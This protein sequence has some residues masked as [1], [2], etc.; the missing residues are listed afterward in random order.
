MVQSDSDR[1]FGED[2][3]KWWESA[4]E[5]FREIEREQRQATKEGK[6]KH[7]E[8]SVKDEKSKNV[9]AEIIE[10]HLLA[11]EALL[12]KETEKF[13]KRIFF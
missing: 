5:I 10:K 9:P 13:E 1:D 11:G 12:A 6:Q 8:R 7:Q 2:E 3:V 4:K